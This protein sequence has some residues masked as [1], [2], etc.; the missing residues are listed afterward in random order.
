MSQKQF[1]IVAAIAVVTGMGASIASAQIT[2][3]TVPI[4]NPGNAAD[5][6]TGT[7]YGSVAYTY[8]IGT[9]EVTNAQ[10]AAFLSAV[11]RTDTHNLYSPNMG[12]SSIGSSGGITR[13]GSPGSYTYSTINGRANNPV[14]WVSFW[15]SCRFANWLHNGQPTGLQNAS[16]TESGAYTLGGVTN[17]VN[18]SVTRKVGWR[19]AVTNENEW[20]KAAYYQPPSGG[21]W[22]YPTSSNTISQSQANYAINGIGLFD[23]TPAGTYAPN[24]I[25]TFDMGGNVSEWNESNPGSNYRNSRG[26]SFVTESNG[27]WAYSQGF[28]FATT[29]TYDLGFRVVQ[30]GA[31]SGH[32]NWAGGKPVNPV[33]VQFRNHGTMTNVGSPL[34]ATID[35]NGDF[36]LIAPGLGNYDITVKPRGYLRRTIQADLTNANVTGAVLNMVPANIVADNVIDLSDY[37]K[38]VVYFNRLASDGDWNTADGDGVMPSDADI[39]GD[40]VVDLTDYTVLILNFNMVGDN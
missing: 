28:P 30:G 17:P 2:I 1:V 19:W 32:I 26:G 13:L 20:Y 33:G 4:G 21:Y 23:T 31:V 8:R 39:N 40:G 5:L 37:T 34:L 12:V 10:Y 35:A 15:D 6:L 38:L 16:T 9:T 14:N 3:P 24:V 36:S 18:A 11:A 25:G 29:E 22:L 7:P 27:L